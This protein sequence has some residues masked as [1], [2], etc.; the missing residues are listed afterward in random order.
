MNKTLYSACPS[1]Q[2]AVKQGLS[3]IGICNHYM[4]PPVSSA[5]E[6]EAEFINS[7]LEKMISESNNLIK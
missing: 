3:C 7:Y 2:A 5:T 1:A 4:R 6:K